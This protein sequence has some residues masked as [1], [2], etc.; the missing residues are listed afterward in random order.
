M[1]DSL[2]LV[3]KPPLLTHP[4]DVLEGVYGQRSLTHKGATFSR[5]CNTPVS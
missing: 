1:L 5:P 2:I 3:Q 4:A